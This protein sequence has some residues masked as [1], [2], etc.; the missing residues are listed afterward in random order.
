MNRKSMIS[1]VLGA[2]SVGLTEA[3]FAAV[4]AAE[5]FKSKCSCHAID[6]KKMGPAFK[7]M[8]TDPKALRDTIANGRAMM[9]KFAG[10][11]S[12]EEIDAM[13][14]FIKAQQ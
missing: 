4:D 12:D 13:V 1:L 2:S 3:A 14:D 9:P 10:K 6:E 8:N 11:L 5:I 7:N